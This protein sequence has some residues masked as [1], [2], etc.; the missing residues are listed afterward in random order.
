MEDAYELAEAFLDET[1]S[2]TCIPVYT[3]DDEPDVAVVALSPNPVAMLSLLHP[4][5]AVRIR[6]ML[7]VARR[8]HELLPE[9]GL[10]Y[11]GSL[12]D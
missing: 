11:A 4:S 7:A 9:R 1:M 5:Y 12:R 8:S 2:V 3:A 6:A 10:R